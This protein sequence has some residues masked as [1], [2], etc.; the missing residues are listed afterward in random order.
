LYEPIKFQRILEDDLNLSKSTAPSNQPTITSNQPTSTS[1]QPTTTS[2]Q[3]TTTSNQPSSTSN[4][5][6]TTSEREFPTYN[7]SHFNWVAYFWNLFIICLLF[8]IYIWCI[9][10]VSMLCNADTHEWVKTTLARPFYFRKKEL[11]NEEF[12]LT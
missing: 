5:P 10:F 3:P 7:F 6:K 9:F 4:Q 8:S 12:E 1:N 11:K 2:N